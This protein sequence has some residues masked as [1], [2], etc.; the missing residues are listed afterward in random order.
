MDT[1]P[2]AN[3]DLVEKKRV[4]CTKPS[5]PKLAYNVTLAGLKVDFV[6]SSEA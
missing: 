5:G 1:Q 2:G 3:F 4:M 6:M